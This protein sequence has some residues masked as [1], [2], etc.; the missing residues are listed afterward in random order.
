VGEVLLVWFSVTI[1]PVVPRLTVLVFIGSLGLL[2]TE[3]GPVESSP[4]SEWL[5]TTVMR[6]AQL[7]MFKLL[8]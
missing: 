3:L 8:M 7:A 4:E 6:P 2:V 1:L 5:V